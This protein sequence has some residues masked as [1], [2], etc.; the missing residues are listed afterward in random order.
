MELSLPEYVRF[1]RAKQLKSLRAHYDSMCLKLEMVV[2][3]EIDKFLDSDMHD[4]DYIMVP[5]IVGQISRR[6][7]V[8]EREVYR[9]CYMKQKDIPLFKKVNIFQSIIMTVAHKIQIK[10]ASLHDV[11]DKK[12][13]KKIFLQV[14]LRPHSPAVLRKKRKYDALSCSPISPSYSP[15]SPSYSPTSPSYS[16]TSPSYS[17]TSFLYST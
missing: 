7:D 1:E 9:F 5:D 11:S 3:S 2:D 17:P 14:V 10:G 13:S 12:L 16:P 15:T 4:R 8:P 6:Y